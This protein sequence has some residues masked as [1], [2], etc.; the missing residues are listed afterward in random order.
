M[1]KSSDFSD[2]TVIGRAGTSAPI[3]WL[4]RSSSQFLCCMLNYVAPTLPQLHPTGSNARLTRWQRWER[5]ESSVLGGAAGVSG[6]AWPHARV[7]EKGRAGLAVQKNREFPG[8]L[9]WAAVA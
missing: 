6:L 3:G 1:E 5:T 2:V 9:L 4:L 7:K 8:S